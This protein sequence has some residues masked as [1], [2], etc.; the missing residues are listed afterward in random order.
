MFRKEQAERRLWQEKHSELQKIASN[1]EKLVNTIVEA[2]AEEV[3]TS[4]CSYVGAVCN[5]TS[6]DTVRAQ[7]EA[8]HNRRSAVL[9]GVQPRA[10]PASQNAKVIISKPSFGEIQKIRLDSKINPVEF[11]VKNLIVQQDGKGIIT[12]SCSKKSA[13]L[14]TIGKF[15]LKEEKPVSIGSKNHVFKIHNVPLDI[16][17]SLVRSRICETYGTHPIRLRINPYKSKPLLAVAMIECNQELYE[18]AK[19]FKKILIGWTQC[20]VDM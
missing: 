9:Q 20:R 7:N 13:F 15:G 8:Q 1:L 5:R 16:D 12:L 4:Q 17:I 11:E 18:K 10:E 19:S 6:T 3:L 2:R 14:T